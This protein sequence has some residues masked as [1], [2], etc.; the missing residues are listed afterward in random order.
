MFFLLDTS[1]RWQ[2]NFQLPATDTMEKIADLHHDIMFYL[3]FI[4]VFVAVILVAAIHYFRDDNKTTL[5]VAFAHHTLLEKVW[6]Y[7]PAFIILTIA[8]PSFSLLYSIDAINDPKVTA[9]IIGHQWYWSYETTSMLDGRDI[10]FD[11]YMLL[12]E[13][14]PQGG[15][16]LLEVDN[17]FCLPV[18]TE[19]RL[20]IT[21]A[22][23]I[24]S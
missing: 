1:S 14:L 11:S 10:N 20:L 2:M 18:N 3:I 23:V 22:D 4:T 19:I 17:R 24:H 5:R 7:I 12:E 8:S 13:D 15:L 9:K 21:G 6:T 16:R